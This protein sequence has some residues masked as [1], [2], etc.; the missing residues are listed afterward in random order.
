VRGVRPSDFGAN[1]SVRAN[2]RAGAT[3][4]ALAVSTG[5][6]LGLSVSAIAQ[7]NPTLRTAVQLAAEGRSVEARRLVEAELARARPGDS[8]YAE[9]LYWRGRLRAHGD[10]AEL[11]LR[12]VAIEYSTSRWA[13][14]A[15]LQLAQL[16][17]AARNPASALALAERVRGDYP[18]SD[19]RPRAAFWAGRAALETGDPGTGCAYL[20]TALAEAEDVELRNQVAHFHG[21]CARVPRVPASATAA[22]RHPGYS[23]QPATRTAPAEPAVSD[24]LAPH[25]SRPGG[26]FVQVAAARTESAANQIA[27]RLRGARHRALVTNG[28]GGY[29]RVRAGPFATR[30][31]AENAAR[32]LRR[33]L[34]GAPFVVHQ[35]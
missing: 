31:D 29:Y 34:G 25:H 13:D 17:M 5:L 27:E 14:D 6:C 8:S 20:D 22:V 15:L 26:F 18:E 12:R 2:H 1:R 23:V 4:R 28:S 9:A 32:E 3:R 19:L 7:D 30:Q 21:R 11:D 35:P 33:L 24:S 10:S 16:A